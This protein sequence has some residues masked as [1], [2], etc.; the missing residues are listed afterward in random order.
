MLYQG[1]QDFW[2]DREGPKGEAWRIPDPRQINILQKI[3]AGQA[4]DVFGLLE[5]ERRGFLSSGD[6]GKL[7]LSI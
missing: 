1:E 3:S 7:S 5:L 4:D 6:T 2:N